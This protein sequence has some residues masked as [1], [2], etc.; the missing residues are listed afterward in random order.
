MIAI[1]WIYGTVSIISTLIIYYYIGRAAP[2]VPPGIAAN[3]SLIRWAKKLFL[4]S[5]G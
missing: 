3:F 1:H 5:I 2:G 4:K